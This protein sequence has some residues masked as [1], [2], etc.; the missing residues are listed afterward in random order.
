MIADWLQHLRP[1][2]WSLWLALGLGL[3]QTGVTLA[4]VPLAQRLEPLLLNLQLERLWLWLAAACG[5]FALRN[6]LEFGLNLLINRVSCAWVVQLRARTLHRLLHTPWQSVSEMAPDQLLATLSEDGERLRQTLWSVLLRLLPGLLQITALFAMLWLIS[7]PLTL[8]LLLMMP[9]LA[10]LLRRQGRQLSARA[11]HLQARWADWLQECVETLHHLALF[12]L[13]KLESA[14][15]KRVNQQQALWQHAQNAT[16][17]HQS[18]ERPLLSTLQLILIALLLGFSAWLVDQRQLSS[19]QLLAYATALGLM[20]DPALWAA[21][22]WAQLQVGKASWARFQPVLALSPGTTAPTPQAAQQVEL[23]QLSLTRGEHLLVE[24]LNW[25]LQPGQRIGL[26]G[27]S[28]SGKTSLLA[29]LAGLVPPDAGTLRW[30]AAWLTRPQAV[31]LVPQRA[32]LLQ[33]SLRDNLCLERPIAESELQ[34][35]IQACALEELIQRL[36]DGLNTL[37][38]PDGAPLSGGERQRVALARALLCQPELLLL[39]ESSSEMDLA[40]ESRVFNAI[41][42]GWPHLSWIMV[43]H[44]PESLRTLDSIW[45]LEKG[46]LKQANTPSPSPTRQVPDE[47]ILAN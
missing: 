15:E 4:L 42:Q 41:C 16:F 23:E 21:E 24:G 20:I 19:G 22:A 27:P 33:R 35:A 26:R 17:F 18:L 34:A 29:V 45:H 8:A 5:L 38:G 2:R 14:Q 44:R 1:W 9:L 40:T 25:Q 37:L 28:G 13:Y 39:D 43:S 30:P 46:T 32:A 12:R 11:S 47:R 7:W 10:L 3:A 36:P 31:V 6:G